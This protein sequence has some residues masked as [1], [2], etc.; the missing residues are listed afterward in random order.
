MCVLP[1]NKKKVECK[2]GAEYF[3]RMKEKGLY[4]IDSEEIKRKIDRLNLTGIL[5]EGLI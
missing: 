3:N 2:K 5:G 4:T 1:F